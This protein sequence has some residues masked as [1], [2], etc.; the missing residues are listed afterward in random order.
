MEAPYRIVSWSRLSCLNR[1]CKCSICS[2]V[3]V[4]GKERG[5]GE[6]GGEF[7]GHKAAPGEP[8]DTHLQ[9]SSPAQGHKE[10]GRHQNLL[11][12]LFPGRGTPP[13]PTLSGNSQKA[14]CSAS[15]LQQGTALGTFWHSFFPIPVSLW[16]LYATLQ[17]PSHC[18]R[19]CVLCPLLAAGGR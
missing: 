5:D 8:Q 11:Q 18:V 13:K 10:S 9:S 1:R 14:A 16:W 17:G 19:P 12:S 3:T 4:G 2:E 6:V 15:F 7:P